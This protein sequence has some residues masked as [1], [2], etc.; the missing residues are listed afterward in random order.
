MILLRS[1]KNEE[2]LETIRH[3][4]AHILAMAVQEIF[5]GTQV[6][7]G[8]IIENGFYY[9]FARKEP[10][11]EDDLEKIENKM[12]EIVDRDVPTT[13]EV[14][15]RDDAVKHFLNIGEK[16]K[17]E[18][19]KSIPSE[20]E[21]SIYHHGKWNGFSTGLTQYLEDDLVIIVLEHTSFNGINALTDKVKKIVEEN[22]SI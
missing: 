7:I 6:T 17:A 2:G 4:T 11:T 19:I 9:D 8:P 20:E 18:I 16:Y 10:F 15:K 22:F 12:K 3:D 21:V 13:R 14:W 1:E 5:P